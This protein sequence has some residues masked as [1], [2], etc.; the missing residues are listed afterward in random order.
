MIGVVESDQQLIDGLVTDKRIAASSF[1]QKLL[2]IKKTQ[3]LITAIDAIIEKERRDLVQQLKHNFKFIE[4]FRVKSEVR[5]EKGSIK[6]KE[7]RVDCNV[8]NKILKPTLTITNCQR[9]AKDLLSKSNEFTSYLE[10]M[11]KRNN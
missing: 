4:G 9:T 2:M 6:N 3:H 1:L 7:W 8:Q 10:S 5:D 11:R